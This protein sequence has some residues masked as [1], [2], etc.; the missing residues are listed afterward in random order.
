MPEGDNKSEFLSNMSHELRTPLNSLL[1]LAQQLADNLEGNLTGKQVDFAKTIYGSGNDL[2]TLINDILDLSKVESGKVTLELG[3][4]FFTELR[5]HV[6]RTFRHMADNKSSRF[7]IEVDPNLPASVYTDG[8]RLKQVL[9]NLLS[10]AFKFTEKGEVKL[11]MAQATKGWSFDHKILNQARRVIA[12]SVT[13]TGTGIP[14]DRRMVIF[15]AFQQADTGT[16]R[17]YGG[18]GLGLSISREIARLLGGELCL[19]ESEVGKGSTFT[20]FLPDEYISYRA[21]QE[22]EASE[23]PKDKWFEEISPEAADKKAVKGISSARKD[24]LPI[25]IPDDRQVIQ[26]GERVILIVE[27]DPQFAKILLDIAHEKGFKGV[28]TPEGGNVLELTRQFKADAIT[29][30]IRL[31]DVDGWT[32]LDR[33]KL[34]PEL[35]HIPVHIITVEEER[36]RG[37]QRGAFAYLEKPVS[38]NRLDEAFSKIEGFI[39]KPK[40]NLLVVEDNDDERKVIVGL[41]GDGDIKIT[42]VDTG[43]KALDALKKDQFD[44]MVLDLRLPDISG[45]EVMDEMERD[46]ALS[47]IPIVV[48]TGKG[49]TQKEKT[50]L[51]QKAMS[52]IVKGAGSAERLLD[53]TALFLHRVASKLPEPKRK[54]IEKLYQADSALHGKK[55]LIV[56]D[57]VRNI[58]ALTTLLERYNMEILSAENGRDSIKILNEK[59]DIDLVLMDIMMPEMDGY[60]TTKRIRKISEFKN[61]PIIA[62]TAKAMK[63]DREKC[64]EAGASDYITKPVDTGQLLSL[65]RVWLFK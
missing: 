40:K 53:E 3:N 14:L 61:L 11:R 23:E 4:V 59:K 8:N 54:M 58:F 63:G 26:K 56:D 27:D 19:M 42:A 5:D 7:T 15:E 21:L 13:D 46:P 49:L 10:N 35:R 33:L 28:V 48:F 41:L 24:V 65:I 29:L 45:F 9:K 30:D 31:P 39:K 60:E 37:L 50:R 55:V 25:H 20:L 43:K 32:V 17:K 16:A 18:T 34:D 6:D 38:R 51:Q 62:L 22:G 64:I 47:E 57:D 2:L 12:F 52:V 36:L 44:C 1:I